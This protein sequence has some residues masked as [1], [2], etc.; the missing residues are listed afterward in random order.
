MIVV[1]LEMDDKD[2]QFNIAE[3]WD[4]VTVEQFMGI[5]GI[6]EE[7]NE[8]NKFHTTVKLINILT[9][10]GEEIIW[11][12]EASDFGKIT[13]ALTF[14]NTKIEAPLKT[15]VMVN[16][17]EYFVKDNFN[18]LTMGEVIT[19]EQLTDATDGNLF[20]SMDKL[21][22]IF[23]R[24]K[25]ENGKLEKFNITF[26]ERAE[27]FKNLSVTDIY[28]LFF[29]FQSGE[30]QSPLTTQDSLESQNQKRKQID[31]KVSTGLKE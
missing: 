29:S 31:L 24:K 27:A 30:R 13:Q 16:G 11:S 26:L 17:E 21:L 20:K 3:S 10:I 28:T 22:T 6:Q 25:K 14:V 9:G 1:N 15:S 19:I 2:Y 7:S 12:M 23:L 8:V 5:V 18:D 4:E